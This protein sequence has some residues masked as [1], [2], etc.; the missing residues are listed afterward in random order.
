MTRAHNFNP[1][2][3]VLPLP[4]LEQAREDLLDFRGLGMGILEISHR[5]AE[6]EAYLHEIQSNLRRLLEIP[7]RYA[8]LFC[9]GGATQQFSMVPLCFARGRVGHYIVSGFFADRA[10][11]E[12]CRLASAH[13]CGTSADNGYRTLPSIDPVPEDAAYI[14]FTSNNTIVGTQYKEDPYSGPIRLICDASSDIL[15][16]TIDVS[17]YTLIYAGAQKNLGPAGT[18]LVIVDRDSLEGTPEGLPS[19]LDYR[20]Y[21]THNSLYNT[22]AVFP[23]YMVGRMLEWIIAEGGLEVIEARNRA[24]ASL[25]Y[26]VIDNSSLYRGY[27]A[28]EA[29][30]I[31]NAT[32]TFEDAAVEKRFLQGAAKEKLLGLKGHKSLG[33]IR[34]SMYNALPMDSVETLV[35]FMR[36]FERTA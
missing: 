7:D 30:S 24:K 20:T 25:V 22:P 34:V 21:V 35:Q 23:I 4:V 18:T 14:H 2:P 26:D 28:K 9:A 13:C 11:Q 8:I 33:G 16:R 6:F 32:F 5:S 27:A 1:G 31:M 12:A 17:R 29:R 36:E 3:A 19:L 15:H 10:Y